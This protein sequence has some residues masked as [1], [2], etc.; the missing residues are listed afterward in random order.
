MV[1]VDCWNICCSFFVVVGGGLCCCCCWV[2]LFVCLVFFLLLELEDARTFYL[3]LSSF[4]F[5]H[6]HLTVTLCSN[7]SAQEEE[8]IA[9]MATPVE[10]VSVA[11]APALE[12]DMDSL[13]IEEEQAAMEK[14]E[15]EEPVSTEP[16]P[17]PEHGQFLLL[18]LCCHMLL[19]HYFICV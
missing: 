12:A 9:P 14:M 19:L 15:P 16:E 17:Q 2:F 5:S 1:N 4:F 13:D 6:F 3:F 7:G 18:F 8:V 11:E 10:P